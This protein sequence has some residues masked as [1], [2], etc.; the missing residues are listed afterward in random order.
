MTSFRVRLRAL[1]RRSDAEAELDEEL[2]YHLDR[3]I[4][5]NVSRGMSIR[6][7]TFAARRAFGNVPYLKEEV[8]DTWGIAWLEQL[9]QDVRFA[10]RSFK[11]SPAFVL[12]VVGT[13]ALALGLNTTVFTI[14]NAYVLRPIQV[15][16]PYSLFQFRYY[17]Q[18]GRWHWNTWDEYQSVRELRPGAETFA[19][20]HLFS[21]IDGLPMFG[22]LATG[23]TF[24]VLGAPVELG[25]ALLPE[26]AALPNGAA[27]MVLSH[28]AWRSRFGADSGILGRKV[29][30]R[31]QPLTVVG[32]LSRRFQGINSVP[33]D[34][35]APITLLNR[36]EGPGLQGQN[37][38][39]LLRIIVRLRPGESEAQA[40]AQLTTWAS[41]AM[42]RKADSLKA[43]SVEL[44]SLA[45]ALPLDSPETIATFGTIMLAFGLVLLIACANVANVM[46]AR[47][48]ARQ[49]EI[50][51]RLALG[52]E[53][54]RLVRQL[55]TESVLLALPAAV[56]GFL[57]SRWT[58]EVGVRAMFAS[59][60]GNFSPYLRVIPLAP[61]AR[62]FVFILFIAVAAALMFGLI[63]AIQATRPNIVQASR[64]DF[65]TAF[66][67][68]RLR[69]ALLVS[70][71]TVCA[72]LLIST[73]ILLRGA[74]KARR[75]DTG[76][77]ADN[78][79]H[80]LLDERTRSAA[81][82]KLRTHSLVRELA[83]SWSS[84]LDGS[85]PT[86]AI[87][88]DGGGRAEQTAYNFVSEQYFSI[89][90]IPLESGRGFNERETLSGEQVAVVSAAFARR[91]WP[92]ADP[93]GQVVRIASD[94]PAAGDLDRVRTARVIGVARNAVSGW[95][96]TGLER[97]VIYYPKRFDAPGMRILARVSGNEE[98][99]RRQIDKDVQ[100]ALASSP[101][102]EIHT[103]NDF[104]STQIYPFKAF[105]WVSS[106]LGAIAL[107]LTLTGIYGV[108]SYLVTQRTKEIGI[109]MALGASMPMVVSLVV[110]QSFVF[111]VVGIAIGVALSLGAS[112]VFDS[113]LPIV[114][115]FDI[116]GYA[117][118]AAV[119][120]VAALAASFAPAR[121]AARVDPL[122]ALREE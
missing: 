120:L 69:G 20:H 67:P 110:R 81:V 48:I 23:E 17:D 76:V 5:R 86:I 32:V 24:Q 37:Q 108:L 7:A 3:E 12:T 42:R 49:R 14:F 29:I 113:V 47:G 75:V 31:A 27:V 101:L 63:P 13:I 80:I 118:G 96:G 62:V 122:Q 33:P 58:I 93:I 21:R 84:P 10:L 72:L 11:R 25:R 102:D 35:W 111:A 77:K 28:D 15:R 40:K 99:A 107:L 61:D 116:V 78:V 54:A 79:V 18:R 4:D 121:R 30:V 2:R 114:N 97:P 82:E 52:A 105:S 90:G 103:L 112:R 104:L 6:D 70:Q 64:G 83:G 71:I 115:T 88:A 89:L 85:F 74:E 91:V 98:Q 41:Q 109:R 95:I 50:G 117:S 36:L 56:I 46:L 57:I 16:D 94:V 8:R 1:L 92:R 53:R 51:I 55:L 44:M 34:F 9:R 119:V 39:D 60:P 59:V 66:R 73:S 100:G 68:G 65:D 22:A 38:S 19:Y 106:A 26:D 87:R 43:G 45:S